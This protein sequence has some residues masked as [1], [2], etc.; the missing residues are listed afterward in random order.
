M[1]S[2]DRL[3][4]SLGSNTPAYTKSYLSEL[5]ASTPSTPPPRRA[6][7]AIVDEDGDVSLDVGTGD[8]DVSM[9]VFSESAIPAES[10]ILAAKQ[11]RERLRTTGV[12]ED[13][14]SLSVTERREDDGPH[15]ESRL[16]REEDEL[17]DGDDGTHFSRSS[18]RS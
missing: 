13:F 6:Q 5:K 1:A 18:E 14:I 12:S 7:Q 2:P 3:G 10:S 16:A 15:P 11:K 9:D 4:E 8:E 17:G